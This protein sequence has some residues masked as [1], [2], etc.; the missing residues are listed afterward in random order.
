MYGG[1]LQEITIQ[2]ENCLIGA[3]YDKFGE[4]TQMRRIS[5]EVCEA[6]VT[7]LISPTFWGWI[8]QFGGKMKIVS[9]DI[10]VNECDVQIAT[11]LKRFNK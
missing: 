5:E 8:F 4:D 3:V 9:P 6:T 1:Q 10:I 2:F 11:L 7:V